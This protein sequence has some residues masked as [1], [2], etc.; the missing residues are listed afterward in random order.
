MDRDEPRFA[1]AT[2]EMMETRQ[3]VIP[4]F[5]GHY[6]FDKPP[7]TYWW[8]RLH[9]W[10]GGK[11]E[12]SA[13]FHSILAAW[14]T[15][16]VIARMG[17]FLYSR[18]AGTLAAVGF[19]SCLQ[20]MIHG[21]LCVA[22]MPMILGVVA[23]MDALARVLF[24]AE[25]EDQKRFGW[26]FWYL[27]AALAFGF[28]AKGPIAWAVPLLA[29]LLLWWP[30]GRM[31]LPWR[32][33]QLA[34]AFVLAFIVVAI[35]G[36]PAM[37][38]TDWKYFRV[39]IGEHVVERGLDAFH[40]RISI[41]GVYLLTAVVS[42]LPWSAFA[43]KAL[44]SGEKMKVDSKRA[45]LVSWFVAPIIIFSFYATQLPHYILPG[46]PAFFLLLFRNGTLPEVKGRGCGVSFWG[47][48]GAGLV[49]CGILLAGL[50]WANDKFPE[51]V[52]EMYPLFLTAVAAVSLIWV[53]APFAIRYL[54]GG[55]LVDGK[56][57]RGAWVIA[58]AYIAFSA[59]VVG[60]LTK[61]VREV[62]V[63]LRMTESVSERMK[64]T[65]VTIG[66]FSFGEPSGVFYFPSSES[67]RYLRDPASLVRWLSEGENRVG[68]VRVKV[69]KLDR[70]FRDDPYV[71]AIDREAEVENLFEGEKFQTFTVE[72]FNAARTTWERL[73][74]AFPESL[75]KAPDSVDLT[76]SR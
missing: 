46:F 70:L 32:Q 25:G 52:D 17:E 12:I 54:S 48:V 56:I 71:P 3:W 11:T 18:A 28:L 24:A 72:G 14:L 9:Y 7:L 64:Q 34:S 40:G 23:T 8:M 33:L 47:T 13:R 44:F 58:F 15:A 26:N 1:E 50:I 63:V 2:W 65:E 6:R 53:A 67:R 39:G 51:P 20:V 29:L 73:V 19:L 42:L 27:V 62:H 45:F 68:I 60:N 43:W 37:I 38:Q 31:R 59:L 41:P 36:L 5:D 22:D 61:Q 55:I 66:E 57:T 49:I 69:W 75:A 74:I 16:L 10:I 4:Y 21:R 76:V 35:W 30:F